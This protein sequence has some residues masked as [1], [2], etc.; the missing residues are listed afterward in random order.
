MGRK[1]TM[2]KDVIVIS[3][4]LAFAAGPAFAQKNPERNVYYGETH[5]HTSWSFDAFAFGDT[6]HHARDVLPVRARPTRA[7]SGRLP[8]EDHQAARLG[9][10]HR[11]S[12]YV[13]MIQEANNPV[14][15]LRQRYP[16]P[17]GAEARRPQ[18][19][20]AH[21]QGAVGTIAKDH[22]GQ[23][24]TDPVVVAPVWKRI[25]DLADK[26][27]RPGT[28][29]TFAAYEWTSNSEL[30]EP[31]PQHLLSSTRRRYRRCRSRSID[32]TD[33]RAL[34]QLDGRPARGG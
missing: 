14:S 28:F 24:F 10:G 9:R 13:G 34:W 1:N 19:S 20:D 32:S 6:S 5:L 25:V 15:P 12:E 11:P 31:A 27:Y 33:P 16:C 17:P 21:L 7:S 22:A 3:C 30:Q 29:T 8:G 18:G 4:L 23:G 26:Y 2:G